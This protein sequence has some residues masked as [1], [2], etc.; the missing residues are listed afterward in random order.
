[1]HGARGPS[2]RRYGLL[3]RGAGALARAGHVGEQGV[4]AQERD[5]AGFGVLEQAEVLRLRIG[6]A[7]RPGHGMA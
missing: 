5:S 2:S 1:M 6:R 4:L 7:D 3:G